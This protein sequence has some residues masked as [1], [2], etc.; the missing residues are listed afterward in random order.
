M[1]PSR[2]RCTPYHPNRTYRYKLAIH[3]SSVL[4]NQASSFCTT[5]ALALCQ[6][7]N[8]SMSLCEP[9]LVT[10]NFVGRERV[11]GVA[12]LALHLA[13]TT[14]SPTLNCGA[15][16]LPQ[17]PESSTRALDAALVRWHF[18]ATTIHLADLAPPLES[19]HVLPF[20][21]VCGL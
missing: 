9:R 8:T 21:S 14:I 18:T 13:A 7:V 20:S 1:G 6:V 19:D 11:H 12:R 17:L 3:H 4:G 15:A 5:I 16:S 2:H 10:I